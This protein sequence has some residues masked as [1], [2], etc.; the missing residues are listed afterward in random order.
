MSR[1]IAGALSLAFGLIL[2]AGYDADDYRREVPYRAPTIEEAVRIYRDNAEKD[3]ARDYHR[4]A[5][6]VSLVMGA[7]MVIDGNWRRRRARAEQSLSNEET[8]IT[9]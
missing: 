8:E 1:I 9:P 5:I 7:L 3:D 6:G 4:I 2:L